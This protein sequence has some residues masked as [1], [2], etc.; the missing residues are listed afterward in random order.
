M[1]LKELITILME[2]KY[3]TVEKDYERRSHHCDFTQVLPKY[4]ISTEF[5]SVYQK[6]REYDNYS[7]KGCVGSFKQPYVKDK[8]TTIIYVGEDIIKFLERY[9]KGKEEIKVPINLDEDNI[10]REWIDEFTRYS[11]NY[12][13]Y[14]VSYTTY[15]Y[16]SN[17]DLKKERLEKEAQKRQEV[18]DFIKS[19]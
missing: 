10:L 19:L 9:D 17:D 3:I 8:Y 4:I 13:R 11:Y 1:E 18:D 5:E 6:L 15:T 7:Q 14:S 2:K 12:K 16:F